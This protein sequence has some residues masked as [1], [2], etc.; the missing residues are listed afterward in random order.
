MKKE[1]SEKMKRLSLRKR[2]EAKF[3]E[4]R[5]LFNEYVED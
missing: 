5:L 3:K 4:E 1:S 2:K